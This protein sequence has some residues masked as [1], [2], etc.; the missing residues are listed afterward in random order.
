MSA[1]LDIRVGTAVELSR[2]IGESDV[3]L[4]AGITGDGGRVHQDETYMRG[5]R[6]GR[7]LVQGVYLIG[8]MSGCAVQWLETLPV[9]G[10]SY[11]YD[12]VRFIRPVFIGDTI[13]VRY[14]VTDWNEPEAM[15]RARVT[16]ANEAGEIVAAATHLVKVFPDAEAGQG[17]EGASGPELSSRMHPGGG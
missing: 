11:G 14:E 3:Y 10:V 6:Y 7:R 4:F 2:T 1:R 12:R 8:L 15:I 13:R 16:C 17:R 5:T 9:P